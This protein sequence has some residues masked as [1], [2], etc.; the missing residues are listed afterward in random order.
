[1]L[2][3]LPKRHLGSVVVGG[4]LSALLYSHTNNL[5]LIINKIKKPHR[6]EKINNKNALV[7]WHKL[8]YLL[9]NSGLNLLGVKAQSTRIKEEEISIT[10]RDARVIKYT[11]DKAIIF[12]DEEVFGLP[13]PQKENEDFIVLDWIVTKSCQ[14]HDHE[15]FKTDDNLV[16]EVYFYPSERIDGNH[17]KKKDLVSISYLNSSQLQDFE[18]SDTYVKFKVTD[19]MKKAGIGG[20][21]CGGNNQYALKLE[22]DRREVIKAKMHTYKNTEKLEFK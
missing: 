19:M 22:V 15:F 9:S 14:M 7:Q 20:R 5:P 21:K 13:T 12:D 6:F 11:Y 18:Y 16:K 1:L 10:T 17:T 3:T 8:Y 2:L 4:N